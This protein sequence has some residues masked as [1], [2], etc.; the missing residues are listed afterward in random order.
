MIA[1]KPYE[2]QG[3]LQFAVPA[4][5]LGRRHCARPPWLFRWNTF[6]ALQMAWIWSGLLALLLAVPATQAQ[7]SDGD[8]LDMGIYGERGTPHFH[9]YT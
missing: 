2:S 3:R 8:E 4:Y 5:T 9:S 1:I 6:V 7:H